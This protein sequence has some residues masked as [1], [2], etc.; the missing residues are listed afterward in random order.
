MLYNITK[1][2]QKYYMFKTPGNIVKTIA[3]M[4]KYGSK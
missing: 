1:N 3:H 4:V 2:I